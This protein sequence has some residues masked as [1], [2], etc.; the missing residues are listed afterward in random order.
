MKK[1]FLILSF[2]LLF[3]MTYSQVGIGTLT[4]VASAQLDVNS[5]TKGLLPP[6][7]T[8]VQRNA[9]VAPVAGL[10]IWCSNCGNSGETQV[11]NG[12]QWTNM[13]GGVAASLPVAGVPIC[14]NVWTNK[15]LDVAFYRNGDP[16]PKVTDP[17]AWAALTTGAYCYYNN[18]SSSYAAIY[19]KL[20]NW[21]ALND[22]RAVAPSG[23]HIPNSGDIQLLTLCTTGGGLK[24]SGT[25]LWV[26]PNDG[27]TNSTGFTALPGG[28][29]GSQGIFYDIKYWAYFWGATETTSTTASYFM[30]SYNDALI[31]TNGGF[32][33][34]N[35][36]S[37]RCVKD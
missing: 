34:K 28:S 29:R 25:T 19:G 22:P 2:S 20:Y 9:I 26:S 14:S 6:R 33:K 18:D 16:I 5:E 15:N 8:L 1:I 4:P 12:N 24:S 23:W 36:F 21:Y 32:F 10:Q 7:M 31:M 11:Y 13:I 35:G 17:V 37:I 3:F 27:A 30:L